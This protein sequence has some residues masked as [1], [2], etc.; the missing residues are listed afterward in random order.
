MKQQLKASFHDFA[1]SLTDRPRRRLCHGY[2]N[3]HLRILRRED[4]A[5]LP[6]KLG[7][8]VRIT[9]RGRLLSKPTSDADCQGCG[10]PDLGSGLTA[11]REAP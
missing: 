2:D 11:H 3:A 6:H 10:I 7:T 4:T 1:A 8:D 9:R 5:E